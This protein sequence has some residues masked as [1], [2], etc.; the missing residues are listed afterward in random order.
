M[1]VGIVGAPNK[2]KSTLFSA[3][4][5]IDVQVADYPFTTIKP[6]VGTTFVTKECVEKELSTKCKPRN[7]SCIKG[8][9][10]IPVEIIDVAGLVEGAHEGKGMGNQFLNDI[11]MADALILVVDASGKTDPNGNPCDKCNPEDDVK[12]IMNEISEWLAGIIKKHANELSKAKNGV[13]ELHNILTGLK[14][15]K[16]SI[17]KSLHECNFIVSNISL[18]DSN[19]KKFAET[20]IKN[21]KPVLIAANKSDKTGAEQNIIKL[22]SKFGENNVIACS[23]AVELALRKAEKQG[24]IEYNAE[25]NSVTIIKK[26]INSMQEDALKYMSNFA[27]EH[28]TGVQQI[29]NKIYFELLGNIVV[30]PVED[31]NKYTDHFGNVLPDAILIKKGATTFDLA[32]AIHTELANSMLYAVDAR[33]KKR[34]AKEYE[35]KDNDVVKIV[36]AAK[37]K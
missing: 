14:I 28:G 22:K 26:D 13:E 15:S 3:L 18:S 4:T 11:G 35:L 2:G 9:R 25:K 12:V 10:M 24:I 6:N 33:T 1:L 23:A 19:I 29:V 16:E 31:E 36:S 5:M 37:P 7:S 30:Y 17:E 21:A 32:N 8:T 20:L 27:K 34:L